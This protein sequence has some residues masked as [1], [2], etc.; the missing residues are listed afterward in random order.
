MKRLIILITL[1]STI[2]S[3]EK[4]EKNMIIQNPYINSK[5][6]VEELTKQVRYYSSEKIY[7]FRYENFNC[8][9]EIYI[10]DRLCY[11]D[12]RDSKAGS[13]FDINHCIYKSGTQKLTYR[14][15][16]AI[17]GSQNVKTFAESTYLTFQLETYDLN[18]ESADDIVYQKYK[19]PVI[20]SKDENGNKTE[21]FIATGREYYEGS[22]EFEVQVPYQLKSFENAEDLRKLDSKALEA[23]LV[24][25]YNVLRDVYKNKDYDNIAK[26]SYNSLKD[27]FISEYAKKE[28]I[29]ATW[30]ELMTFYKDPSLE[31]QPIENYKMVFFADGKL[32]ALMQATTDNRLRGNTSLWAKVNHDG[33]LRPLFLNS[34]FYIPKGKTEFEVY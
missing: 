15:Y 5:N 23:K 1:F 24:S 3:C 34:Y 7:G 30:N 31:M 21:K 16:P 2:Q 17:D 8:F 6:I 12:F 19:T 4:K 29:E 26:T 33:G 20:I 11:K 18:D 25:K 9:I 27:Q 13:S 22:F 32:V 28:T 14:M 10:N